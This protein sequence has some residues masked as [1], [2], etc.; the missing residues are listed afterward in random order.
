[1]PTTKKTTVKAAQVAR[2]RFW[3]KITRDLILFVVGIG[4]I[5]NEAVIR[6]GDP[7]ESLILLFAGMVGLPA[8]LRAD[9]L[10]RHLNGNGGK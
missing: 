2:K 7:R 10:R 1:M 8:I 6:Q 4:L 3:Q 5:I 9:E